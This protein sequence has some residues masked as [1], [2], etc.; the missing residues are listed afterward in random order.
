MPFVQLRR[1]S[2]IPSGETHLVGEPLW[3]PTASRFG[4]FNGRTPTAVEW[5]PCIVGDK[6]LLNP[7]QTLGGKIAA[8]GENNL[9]FD[10]SVQNQLTLRNRSNGEVY[11]TFSGAG[12]SFNNL[13]V[14][15]AQKP[16]MLNLLLNGSLNVKRGNMPITTVDTGTEAQRSTLVSP[17]WHLWKTAGTAGRIVLQYEANPITPFNPGV[18]VFLLNVS[19]APNNSGLRTFL[20]GYSAIAGVACNFS[21]YFWAASGQT[22]YHR[23]RTENGNTLFSKQ[24]TGNGA[25]QRVDTTFTAADDGSRW[26]AFDVFYNPSGTVN[27][28]QVWKGT[29]AQLQFGTT[30]SPFE[31]RPEAIERGLCDS[32]YREGL[33]YLSGGADFAAIDVNNYGY[34]RKLLTQEA[35]GRVVNVVDEGPSGFTIRVPTL[36]AGSTVKYAAHILPTHAET[37]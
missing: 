14:T 8:G 22:S 16:G 31:Q 9:Y 1:G 29:C 11:A 24:I 15:G 33:A 6:L 18:D 27:S 12:A 17:N 5:Y 13:G 28:T 7:N 4:V 25:W 10:F 26:A 32:I 36:S 35:G 3:D 21:F 37:V 34:G 30:V 2:A 23:A 19:S 20:H